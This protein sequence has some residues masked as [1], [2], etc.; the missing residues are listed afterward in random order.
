M[1]LEKQYNIFDKLMK[2]TTRQTSFDSNEILFYL[3]LGID[4]DLVTTGDVI[5]VELFVGKFHFF[6]SESAPHLLVDIIKLHFGT[7]QASKIF[8]FLFKL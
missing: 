8:Q 3:F 5:A 6:G 7:R 1:P 4:D 2:D